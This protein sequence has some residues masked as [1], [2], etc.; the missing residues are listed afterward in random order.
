LKLLVL[1]TIWFKVF[2]VVGMLIFCYERSSPP[3]YSIHCKFNLDP[4]ANA[5]LLRILRHLRLQRSAVVDYATVSQRFTFPQLLRSILADFPVV[6]CT[7]ASWQDCPTLV[8]A[9]AAA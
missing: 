7:D 2:S 6:L 3:L 8:A 4:V 9:L 5:R 1:K